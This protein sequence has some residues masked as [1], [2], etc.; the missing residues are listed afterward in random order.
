MKEYSNLYQ[1]NHYRVLQFRIYATDATSNTGKPSSN[2]RSMTSNILTAGFALSPGVGKNAPLDYS[3]SLGMNQLAESTR[4][5]QDEL[6]NISTSKLW[7]FLKLV[8]T[9]AKVAGY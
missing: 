4:K 1:R 2:T 8:E 3:T 7:S 9:R 5:L 6:F